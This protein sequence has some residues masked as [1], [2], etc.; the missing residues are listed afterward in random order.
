MNLIAGFAQNEFN[1]EL[2]DAK[3]GNTVTLISSK[4]SY[5]CDVVKEASHETQITCFTRSVIYILIY[6]RPNTRSSPS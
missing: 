3:L 5:I 6:Q 1:F 2:D 4:Q